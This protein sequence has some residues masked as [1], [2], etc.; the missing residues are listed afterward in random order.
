MSEENTML[1]DNVDMLTEF[2]R[3]KRWLI[4][5]GRFDIRVVE[6]INLVIE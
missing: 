2:R 4:E 6:R 3:M 5:D 1:Q